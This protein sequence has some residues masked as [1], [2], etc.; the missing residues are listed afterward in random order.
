MIKY[1]KVLSSPDTPGWQHQRSTGRGP[2]GCSEAGG[3]SDAAQCHPQSPGGQGGGLPSRAELACICGEPHCTWPLAGQTAEI[4]THTCHPRFP[5]KSVVWVI[6]TFCQPSQPHTRERKPLLQH[7]LG[8]SRAAAS[9]P[10]LSEDEIISPMFPKHFLSF[11]IRD[12]LHKYQGIDFP[13]D[14]GS[15]CFI[16]L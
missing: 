2:A 1:C 16:Q 6:R 14:R 11:L 9:R 10:G 5:R 12:A 3:I 13:I 15:E 4:C 8:Q 7:Q